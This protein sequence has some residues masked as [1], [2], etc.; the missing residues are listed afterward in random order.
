MRSRALH[1]VALRRATLLTRSTPII[2]VRAASSVSQRP[3][4]DYVS[5][6]GALKS[7]FTNSLSFQTPQS[8]TALPTY[9]VVDQNGDVVDPSFEPD[10]P[11]ETIVKLYTDMLYISILDVIMFDAQR[12]GRLSFYMVSAGEEAVPIGSSSVLDREDVIFCQYREQGA[13]RERGFTTKEFMAQ[14]FANKYDNG[15]GRNMPVHYGSKELNIHTISSPLGTQLPHAAG[16]AYAQRLRRMQNPDGK[17]LITVAYFGEGSASGADFHGA[18]NIAATRSCPIIFICRNNGYAISTPTLEQYRGD[19]IASRGIG[20]GIDTIRIDGNDIWAVREAVK[21]ARE[22]ALEDGGKPVLIEAMT[23]RV[24]H[25]STSDDSFA[26]RARVE[27]EDWKR[28]D[29][30]I[31]RLRKWMEARGMWDE[32]KEKEARDRLRKEVLTGIRDAE[33]EKKPPVRTM[34]EDTYEELTPDLK[35]QMQE[36]REIMEKYPDEYDLGEYEGGIDSLKQ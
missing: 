14:L 2:T 5:F 9:R 12:Q 30:P 23:Y 32:A 24:S 8:W 15:K 13:F 36:L 3:H 35:A 34:F 11:E 4:S 26:Y 18:L 31:T 1:N 22:L 16:N 17:P 28:R 10:I 19:G 33:K 29:N 27:V 6:P 7:A 21:R 25:H 20:Y